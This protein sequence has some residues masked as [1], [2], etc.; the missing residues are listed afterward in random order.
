MLFQ[1]P[2]IDIKF[3][4]PFCTLYDA[5]ITVARR[6]KKNVSSS[7]FGAPNHHLYYGS[8]HQHSKI[9]IGRSQSWQSRIAVLK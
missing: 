9:T 7:R 8:S 3:S 2:Q 1:N 6:K 5:N 4:L